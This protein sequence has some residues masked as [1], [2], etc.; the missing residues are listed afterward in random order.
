M[1]QSKKGKVKRRHNLSSKS[2]N[3]ANDKIKCRIEK[4]ESKGLKLNV[5]ECKDKKLKVLEC[6]DKKLKVQEK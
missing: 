4:Q 3:K 6:K 2:E 5:L 1:N